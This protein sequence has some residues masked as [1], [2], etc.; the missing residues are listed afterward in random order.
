MVIIPGVHVIN[1]GF[2]NSYLL[3][4]P[5]SLTLI[6]CGIPLSAGKITA[7]IKSIGRPV[8]DLKKILITHS[9][10][11]HIGSLA[12]LKRIS[13]AK[14]YSSAVE[15]VGIKRGKPTRMVKFRGMI[16]VLVALISLVVKIKP[17]EVDNLIADNEEIPVLGGITAIDTA[18]HTPGHMSYYLKS[19]KVLF[20]GDSIISREDMLYS[21]RPLLTWDEK[22]AAAAFQKQKMLSPEIV[23]CG[24]GEVMKEAGK[25]FA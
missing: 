22:K 9:D 3:E 21:S 11:D 24:H 7:Y 6:D 18:G 12:Y 5:E 14:V 8:K 19:F 23:C 16:K 25:K 10:A 13:G 4:E 1:L 17:V 20:A 15:A 2:V